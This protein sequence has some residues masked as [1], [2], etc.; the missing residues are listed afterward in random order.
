MKTQIKL[1]N[2]ER[3]YTDKFMSKVTTV[4]QL[5]TIFNQHNIMI[6]I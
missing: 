5:K 2:A 4:D 1:T 3:Y 6:I